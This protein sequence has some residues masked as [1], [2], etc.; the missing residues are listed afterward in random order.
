MLKD[1]ILQNTF[2]TEQIFFSV[3]SRILF[4]TL[5]LVPSQLLIITRMLVLKGSLI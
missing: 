5:I 2:F 3:L 1:A 4:K